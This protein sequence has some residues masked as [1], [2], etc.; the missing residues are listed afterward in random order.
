MADIN[1]VDFSPD[2]HYVAIGSDDKTVR[3]W[4]L[5]TGEDIYTFKGHQGAVFAI[6][7]SPDGQVL[8]SASADKTIR[9]WQVPK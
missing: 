7:Y 8:V 9:K 1:A 5:A 3:I 6:D 2:N 4:N